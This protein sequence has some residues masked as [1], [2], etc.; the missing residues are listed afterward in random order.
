MQTN[1]DSPIL[2]TLTSLQRGLLCIVCARMCICLYTK[3]LQRGL[4]DYIV[5]CL[6]TRM[7]IVVTLESDN[8]IIDEIY[9]YC[10][11]HSIGMYPGRYLVVD[12]LYWIWRIEAEPSSPLTWL[13]FKYPEYLVSV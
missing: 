8:P 7:R 10:L 2:P 12:G 11:D 13:L 4:F 5:L 9:T 6:N 1:L 3:C